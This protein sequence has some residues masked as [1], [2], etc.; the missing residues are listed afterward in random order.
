MTDR[1]ITGRQMAHDGYRPTLLTEGH[2]PQVVSLPG[3]VQGGYQGPT[4]GGKPTAPT[5]GSGVTPAA[6]TG[7]K[8]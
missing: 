8:K 5:T 7:E 1:K 4:G 3:K 2:K 6:P